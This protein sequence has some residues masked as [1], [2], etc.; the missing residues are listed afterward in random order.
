MKLNENLNTVSSNINSEGIQMGID[1]AGMAHIIS[2]LTDL[3]ED[4]EKTVIREYYSNAL[5]SHRA[6]GTDKKIQISLPTYNEPYFTVQDFGVGMSEHEMITIYS[7]YGKSTKRD[8]N[9]QIGAFGLG[10]KSALSYTNQFTVSSVKNGEKTVSII[11]RREDG[12]SEMDIVSTS[13]TSEENGVTVIIPVSDHSSFTRKATNFFYYIDPEL[14]HISGHTIKNFTSVFT[15]VRDLGWISVS[16]APHSER[17]VNVLMGGIVYPLSSGFQDTLESETGVETSHDICILLECQIGDVD[18]TPSR[19]SLR[20]TPRTQDTIRRIYSDF[21]TASLEEIQGKVDEAENLLKARAVALNECQD[22]GLLRVLYANS[23]SYKFPAVLEKLTY[24]G[25]P[26]IQPGDRTEVRLLKDSVLYNDGDLNILRSYRNYMGS[27]SVIWKPIYAIRAN[28]NYA[29]FKR[30]VNRENETVAQVF[31]HA[32]KDRITL[33]IPEDSE[34]T[35]EASMLDI[36]ILSYSE[37]KKKIKDTELAEKGSAPQ[38]PKIKAVRSTV[39]L[40]KDTVIMV[41]DGV[42]TVVRISELDKKYDAY[43]IPMTK[44]QVRPF[45][46]QAPEYHDFLDKA[47]I[48]GPTQINILLTED[49]VILVP[50]WSLDEARNSTLLDIKISGSNGEI[51]DIMKNVKK[52]TRSKKRQE[53]LV[54]AMASKYAFHLHD[55]NHILSGK[56]K[57]P[58]FRELQKMM[59]T[60]TDTE[61]KVISMSPGY[62]DTPFTENMLK[63]FDYYFM[64]EYSDVYRLYVNN[65]YQSDFPLVEILNVMYT[66]IEKLKNTTTDQEEE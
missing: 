47:P 41:E 17:G 52:L 54:S 44:E 4:P 34:I 1:E 40:Y 36:T 27:G 51:S 56:F 15:K 39:T 22:L 11:S 50:T 38:K 53:F 61:R 42:G 3:Y 63:D 19:E 13:Q 48:S 31:S 2:V 35:D 37:Y 26:L 5:D 9:D 29:S 18:L 7:S 43:K 45:F 32:V 25:S 23:S 20:E 28:V 49:P 14:F 16:Y 66:N 46:D 62:F 65:R 8:S 64:S 60:V 6:A 24:E 58:K 12:G 33:M 57:D 55:N 10:C 21:L 59:K 30:W